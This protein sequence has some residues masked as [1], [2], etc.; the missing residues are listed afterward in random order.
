VSVIAKWTGATV[1]DGTALGTTVGATG[2]TKFDTVTVTGGSLTVKNGGP[3]SPRI[4]QVPAGAAS[5]NFFLWQTALGGTFPQH[6]LRVYIEVASLPT[7][8][9]AGLVS[10]RDASNVFVWWLD[11]SVAGNLR[12]RNNAGLA[13]ASSSQPLP[14]NTVLRVEVTYTATTDTATAYVYRGDSQIPFET[15]SGTGFNNTTAAQIRF[16]TPN[17]A[18]LLPHI[19]YDEMAFANTADLIGPVV[20]GP[21]SM[22]SVWDGTKETALVEYGVWDGAA[23]QYYSDTPYIL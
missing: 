10:A 17:N 21:T 13:V 9:S 19:Y 5:N 11:M 23:L 22:L 6:A 1:A 8:N 4:E 14:M 18:Q 20:P 15:L 16:G 7:G 2:D 12:L 3:Y